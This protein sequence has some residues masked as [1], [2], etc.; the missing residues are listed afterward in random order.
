MK[1]IT[2]LFVFISCFLASFAQTR[3]K[4]N[5]KWE[6]VDV[7]FDSAMR[8]PVDTTSSAPIWSIAV[9]NGIQYLKQ[10]DGYWHK[11]GTVNTLDSVLSA[12]STRVTSDKSNSF[13]DHTWTLDSAAVQ[14][15]HPNEISQLSSDQLKFE[16]TDVSSGYEPVY[17]TPISSESSQVPWLISRRYVDQNPQPG[18]EVVNIGFNLSPAATRINSSAEAM[19][20]SM[21]SNYRPSSVRLWEW[22][23]F[24]VK[25][26]NTQIRLSS[27]TINTGT[28]DIDYYMTVNRFYLKDPGLGGFTPYLLDGLGT[29]NISQVFGRSSG[30]VNQWQYSSQGVTLNMNE[31]GAGTGFR[32]LNV[33]QFQFGNSNQFAIVDGAGTFV[34]SNS[35]NI[36]MRFVYTGTNFTDV[37][38]NSVGGLDLS[39]SG[40]FVRLIDAYIQTGDPGSGVA[41]WKMGTVISSSVTLDTTKY[42]EVNIGGTVVK[43]AVV[44]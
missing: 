32:V 8:P 33:D 41:N 9:K 1:K 26:D 42:V 29:D 24:F 25:L 23:Q 12:N 3:S 22:H 36:P 40:H 7:I 38:Q 4:V 6:Y 14:L 39:P 17:I 11:S 18:N 27:Y 30:V 20:W 44:N 15:T 28:N 43:L 13:S 2:A 19:G 34:N 37:I 35:G 5:G 10:A 31:S 16:L 21:E